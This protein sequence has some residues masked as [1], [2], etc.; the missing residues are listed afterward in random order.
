MPR[1]IVLD[2]SPLGT[3][4]KR[5]GVPDADAC[6]QWVADCRRAG[7]RILAP[8][9]AYYELARELER[10]GNTAALARLDAFCRVPGCYLPVTDQAV[11]L[12][13][14]LWARARRAGIPTADPKELDCD[15]LIAAQALDLGLPPSELV[16]ATMNIGHLSQF[17]SAELWTKTSLP[18][19]V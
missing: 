8:A 4:T 1:T 6:R 14:K 18:W 11:H 19:R 17:V 12:A 9:I 13:V 10:S 5:R 2:T 15:V 7:H 16:V 3:V